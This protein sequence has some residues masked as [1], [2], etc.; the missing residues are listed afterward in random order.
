MALTLEELAQKA[1]ISK[2]YLSLIENGRIA[3]PPS[4]EKLRR[5]E[6]A[7]SMPANELVGQAQLQRTPSDVRSILER[8]VR[9]GGRK[10][11]EGLAPAVSPD[12]KPLDLDA[13]YMSGVLQELADRAGG[14]IEP[15]GAGAVAG[16]KTPVVNKVSA[17]YPRDFTDL[18]YPPRV[19]D[20][21][22]TAPGVEDPDAFAA[23]VSGDSML[24]KYSEGDIVIFSPLANWKDGSDCF[25]RL[26]DGQTTFKRVFV[27][28][29]KNASQSLRLEPRNSKYSPRIVPREEVQGVY[30]AVFVYRA[31]GE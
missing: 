25:V 3:N 30:K 16:K 12:G 18:N 15:V 26:D 6:Q 2:A 20:A 21:Y 4:D 24:P 11:I 10:G 27:E 8:L 5:I 17:G 19:A 13:A 7:L 14:N 22:I 31:V 28:N 29:G 23:R 1:R 9:Q